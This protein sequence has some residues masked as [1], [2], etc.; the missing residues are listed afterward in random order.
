MSRD[1]NIYYPENHGWITT[2]LKTEEIEYLWKLIKLT[3][4]QEK[5]RMTSQTDGCFQIFDEHEYFFENVLLPCI[6]A[7]EH[8][9][10]KDLR[11]VPVV[12]NEEIYLNGM[13]V[14]YQKENDFFPIHTHNGVYSFVVWMKIPTNF[15]D[16]I[17]D[18]PKANKVLFDGLY[19]SNF[20]FNYTNI[21]GE[22]K[23]YDFKMSSDLEGTL[24]LFPSSL[25]HG[26]YP[27][28]KCND[29]RI[30]VSGNI[31]LK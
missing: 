25:Q 9:F 1:Y 3:D 7:Y 17:R 16:Q 19:T 28:Y 18:I 15:E 21:L 26:V 4:K 27:F 13:W 5:Y 12:N 22:N 14:N 10:G 2:N 20:I 30:S 6:S 31:C 24:L 8:N 11:N 29:E 23:I